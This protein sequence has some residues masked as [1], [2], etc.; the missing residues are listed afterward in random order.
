MT[1]A[2]TGATGPLS[3]VA[4]NA[5]L[6]RDGLSP[7][8]VVPADRTRS[9][10]AQREP[11]DVDAARIDVSNAEPFE[12]TVVGAQRVIWFPGGVQARASE[13]AVTP[14]PE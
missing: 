6:A 3:R 11:P 1:I 4:V 7:K 13:N 8:E 5:P 2:V 12:E 10:P 9:K 14:P